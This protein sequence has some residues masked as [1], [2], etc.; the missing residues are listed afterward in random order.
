[1]KIKSL[2]VHNIA[3]I[4][5]AFLDFENGPLAQG[6]V[7][8]ICGPTGVGKSTLLDAVCL[9]LYGTVPRMENTGMRDKGLNAAIA[10][11][12]VRQLLRQG[13]GDAFAE[14]VFNG[15]DGADYRARW[16]VHRSRGK[17]SGT[18]QAVERLLERLDGSCPP[19]T[20]IRSIDG[21]VERLVG[22][23]FDQFC[24]TTMLAQGQF[25]RF[26]TSNESEKAKILAQITGRQDMARIGRAIYRLAQEKSAEVHRL[27]S[28]LGNTG[29]LNLQDRET[30]ESRLADL[31]AQIMALEDK[32]RLLTAQ[33]APL[34]RR[35]QLEGVLAK[36][37]RALEMAEEQAAAPE[38]VEAAQLVDDWDSSA[39]ARAALAD[40]NSS[41]REME[42]LIAARKTIEMPFAQFCAAIGAL[43]GRIADMEAAAD[44]VRS[45]IDSLGSMR[46]AFERQADVNTQ[47]GIAAAAAIRRQNAIKDIKATDIR[48]DDN[49]KLQTEYS[50]AAEKAKTVADS[51]AILMQKAT[52]ELGAVDF[53][54][55]ASRKGL[56]D[57]RLSDIKELKRVRADLRTLRGQYSR[58]LDDAK[59]K[60]DAARVAALEITEADTRRPVLAAAAADARRTYELAATGVEASATAMRTLL[61]RGCQCPVCR[62]TVNILPEDNS[63]ADARVL[64]RLKSQV[65]DADSA[66]RAADT[67]RATLETRRKLLAEAAE[68]LMVSADATRKA[69]AESEGIYNCLCDRLE[70]QYDIV[71]ADIEQ[72]EREAAAQAEAT[73]GE[74]READRIRNTWKNLTD[75]QNR[76]FKEYEHCKKKYDDAVNAGR[77]LLTQR[78]GHNSVAEEAEQAIQR[79]VDVIKG[80]DGMEAFGLIDAENLDVLSR[81]YAQKLRQYG[82]A[83]ERHTQIQEALERLRNVYKS[84][85]QNRE[86]VLKALPE[87]ADVE[88]WAGEPLKDSQLPEIGRQLEAEAANNST[89]WQR[90]SAVAADA[91]RR[92]KSAGVDADAGGESW[93][94][95]VSLAA[96][97]ASQ[98]DSARRR[99]QL[100]RNAVSEARGAISL[101]REQIRELTDAGVELPDDEAMTAIEQG[102][103][104]NAAAIREYTVQTGA[105]AQ[106]LRADDNARSRYAELAAQLD[107]AR[108]LAARWQAFNAAFG[109]AD[110]DKLQG[111]AMSYVLA[112]LLK[113]ADSYLQRLTGRYTLR[114]QPGSFNIE[115]IDA[116][117][118]GAA[119]SAN[120]SSGGESFMVSLA[121]ALALSDINGNCGAD[122]LFIDEGFGTL[123]DEP[124][125]NAVDMLG[126][127]HRTVGR[128]VGIISHMEMLR[129]HID[130]R[131]EVRRNPASGTSAVRILSHKTDVLP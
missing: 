128:R 38:I 6:G 54:G 96:H 13:A 119:R 47:F 99:V 106:T 68:A 49:K 107:A 78:L 73:T 129:S 9:A 2:K 85:V 19:L 52:D 14:L 56:A 89:L 32:D 87:L 112:S 16:A 102:Q 17:A 65:E 67:R 115:V 108:A 53:D 75:S 29:V 69:A 45:E 26:L 60:T 74:M 70:L 88:C 61:T 110:G 66:L 100:A 57:K 42:S 63:D 91:C 11:N 58:E 24:R 120:T 104:R 37:C 95:L 83:V 31:N 125:Q 46:M 82:K 72:I 39:E 40:F 22:L 113:V 98:I 123:S 117:N 18:L 93:Q 1:M 122:M 10:A 124:L 118:G 7:F 51:S 59:A 101:A 41:C 33:L 5:D 114:C 84:A 81:Q 25:T 30:V 80:I 127:L 79:A 4:E 62:Q 121:L 35:R 130:V 94:S 8:L 43:S 64:H 105:L 28:L 50:V 90:A 55:L 20:R 34:R 15:S 48:I 86:A 103:A 3:S 126:N 27:E 116:D 92:L 71:E 97:D 36:S 77:S 109:S 44:V 76:L 21:A 111:M 12:D 23:R 131:V